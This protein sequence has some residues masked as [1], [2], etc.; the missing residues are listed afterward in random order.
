MDL[1][2]TETQTVA[3]FRELFS[4]NVHYVRWSYSAETYDQSGCQHHL[5]TLASIGLNGNNINR[6]S[7]DLNHGIN[8]SNRC[9]YIRL[10][11]GRLD[12]TNENESH[13]YRYSL[14]DVRLLLD[15]KVWDLV[16]G[17]TDAVTD[18]LDL[19]IDDGHFNPIRH[20]R[21]LKTAPRCEKRKYFFGYNR[22]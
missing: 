8:K 17:T 10:I 15:V 1:N 14:L 4:E 2:T 5:S 16:S 9:R 7:L 18:C 11:V 12:L 6:I 20:G 13:T 21:G 22:L 19:V 3:V